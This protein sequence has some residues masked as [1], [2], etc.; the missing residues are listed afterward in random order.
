MYF[1]PVHSGLLLISCVEA[2]RGPLS[3]GG[4]IGVYPRPE[5]ELAV[6]HGTAPCCANSNFPS[7]W[8]ALL[9]DDHQCGMPAAAAQLPHGRA[10]LPPQLLQL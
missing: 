7:L 10:L 5:A 4:L 6:L 9:Q 3:Q 2:R 8:L 1:W